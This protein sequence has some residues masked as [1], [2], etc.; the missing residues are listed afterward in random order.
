MRASAWDTSGWAR[1]LSTQHSAKLSWNAMS[2][3]SGGSKQWIQSS[4]SEEWEP[5]LTL[6]VFNYAVPVFYNTDFFLCV[7]VYWCRINK[8]KY[9]KH[10]TIIYIYVLLYTVTI[11]VLLLDKCMSSTDCLLLI[12]C[13]IIFI[14]SSVVKIWTDIKYFH[15]CILLHAVIK[16]DTVSP[17]WTLP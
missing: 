9:F 7:L 15:T 13:N 14:V 12:F 5:N 16:S 2:S 6:T 4:H 3:R 11:H 17:V 1:W 8:C 10:I